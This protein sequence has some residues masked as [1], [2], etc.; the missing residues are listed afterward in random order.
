[1]IVEVWFFADSYR[2][3]EPPFGMAYRPH[4]V[5]KGTEEYLG[6]QFRNLKNAPYGEHIKCDIELLYEGVNYSR[7]ITG[8]EF[9][10][11]E[12]PHV[13]GEDVVIS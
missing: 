3:S 6:I 8:V 10:I 12:G 4:F 2:K 11:R 5:I 9:E 13:V 7:L 1:M